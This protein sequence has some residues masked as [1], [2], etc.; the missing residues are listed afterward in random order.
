MFI[1]GQV[2]IESNVFWQGRVDCHHLAGG[3]VIGLGSTS[4]VCSRLLR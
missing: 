4:P 2:G 3:P 1:E